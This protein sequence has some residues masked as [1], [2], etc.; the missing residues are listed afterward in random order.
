LNAAKLNANFVQQDSSDKPPG[1]VLSTDPKAGDK[2]P[3]LAPGQG[4]PTVNVAVAKEP[5]VQV[6]DVAGQDPNTAETTLKDKGFQAGRAQA[7]SDRLPEGKAIGT[8]PAAGT[9]VQKGEF[10]TLL[11]ST[12]PQNIPVP[13]TVGKTQSDATAELLGA[14]FNVTVQPVAAVPAQHGK[15]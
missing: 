8:T 3:K 13:N 6:P 5:P 9:P 12:G 2:L 10:V 1:T 15:V 7:R 11:V 4:N 14:G